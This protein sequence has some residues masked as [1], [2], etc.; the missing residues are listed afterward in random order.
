[1][2]EEAILKIGDYI[3]TNLTEPEEGWPNV[4]IQRRSYEIWA[5]DEILMRVFEHPDTLPEIVVEDFL[6][7]MQYFARIANTERARVTFV[8]AANIAEDI[9]EML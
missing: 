4:Y 9:L 5:A 7:R 3:Q 8:I 6:I 1:M 2:N